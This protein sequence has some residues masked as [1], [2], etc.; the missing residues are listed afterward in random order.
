MKIFLDSANIDEIKAVASYGLLDGVTTNPSIISK[1]GRKFRDAIADIC[2]LVK[3]PVSAEV[4][5]TDAKK[6]VEEGVELASI[7]PNVVVKIPLIQEGIKAVY[8]LSS[9]NIAT[10]VT[11]C[12]S[13]N[14]AFLAAKAGATFISPFLGRL[15]DLGQD[16]LE[17]IEEIREI[18]DNYE[19]DT[20]ILAA[21]IRHPIHFKEVARIGADCATI[22]FSVFNMLFQH[23]MTDSGL[24]KFLDDAKTIQW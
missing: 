9:K 5:A 23:P 10:N 14:Q 15:D 22:P 12:F 21:S 1:S 3:G 13:A 20:Q 19:Y 4:L 24:K 11:L 18:Y 8:E 17:L 2:K 16:G 6:M 7:A